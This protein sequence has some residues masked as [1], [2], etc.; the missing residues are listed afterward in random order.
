M[1]VRLMR[2]RGAALDFS[3]PRIDADIHDRD[4]HDFRPMVRKPTFQGATR[5][6]MDLIP[7]T[8]WTGAGQ[9]CFFELNRRGSMPPLLF[10]YTHLRCLFV[11][12]FLIRVRTRVVHRDDI[13][14]LCHI[15]G[16]HIVP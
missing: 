12:V 2:K 5:G 15:R 6:A 16:A 11:E 10:T 13:L 9:F 8:H 3:A 1:Y 4:T 7:M 14:L